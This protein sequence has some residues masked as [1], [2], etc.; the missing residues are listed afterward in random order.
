MSQQL[1]VPRFF[2]PTPTRSTGIFRWRNALGAALLSL[3][4][5]HGAWAQASDPYLGQ[6]MAVGFNF[7]P[8]GW[9]PANGQLLSIS[10]NSALFALLGTFYG[11]DGQTTFQLPNLQGRVPVGVGTGPGLS[12]IQQGESGGSETHTLTVGEMPNHTHTLV[13]STASA[14]DA[15]PGPSVLLG[16]TQNAGAYVAG[17]SANVALGASSIQPTGG[18]QPF[19]VRNPY[20]GMTWCIATQGVFPSR[21]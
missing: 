21:N 5:T 10:Q 13:A 7:C 1:A 19:S 15:T 18:N 6:V 20:L 8:T 17:A 11:G 4:G 9:L 12:P 2:R 16:Q 14:T 3:C